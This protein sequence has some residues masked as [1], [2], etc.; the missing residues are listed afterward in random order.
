VV[1]NPAARL[2][3]LL[4]AGAVSLVVFGHG[5][6]HFLAP[7]TIKLA[8]FSCDLQVADHRACPSPSAPQLRS[9]RSIPILRAV[10]IAEQS[11]T[12]DRFP[13]ERGMTCPCRLKIARRHAFS[14]L[15]QPYLRHGQNLVVTVVRHV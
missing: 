10:F 9:L 3:Q 4:Q 6:A 1:T 12:G 13:T 14:H 11:A 8:T 15:R 2:I 7:S 5:L